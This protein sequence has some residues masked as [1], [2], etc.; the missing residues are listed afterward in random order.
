M[1]LIALIQ[2]SRKKFLLNYSTFHQLSEICF[3]LICSKEKNKQRNLLLYIKEK[4]NFTL[5]SAFLFPPFHFFVFHFLFYLIPVTAFFFCSTT[6]SLIKLKKVCRWRLRPGLK[7]KQRSARSKNKVNNERMPEC[8][9]LPTLRED[10]QLQKDIK[11]YIF[12]SFPNWYT[13]RLYHTFVL[14]NL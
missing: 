6:I 12:F 9:W 3:Y 5:S 7:Q 14:D 10:I 8:M 1:I 13:T 11:K 2:W 4:K